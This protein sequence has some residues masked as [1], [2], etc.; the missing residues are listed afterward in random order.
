MIAFVNSFLTYLILT[1]CS[2]GLIVLA[3]FCGKKLRDVKDNKD[4]AK[5]S[6]AAKEEN[7]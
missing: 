5:A 2:M 4:A 6:E 7:V 3:V 1:I